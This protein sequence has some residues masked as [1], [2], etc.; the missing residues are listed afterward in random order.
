LLVHPVIGEGYATA[1][2]G[3]VAGESPDAGLPSAALYDPDL[4]RR[5]ASP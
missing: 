5:F 4:L 1:L 3:A 2:D